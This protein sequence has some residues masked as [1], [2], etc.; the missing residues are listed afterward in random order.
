MIEQ[1]YM[2]EIER[3]ESIGLILH[4]SKIKRSMHEDIEQRKGSIII[5]IRISHIGM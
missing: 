5:V 3:I 1:N 2:I 4:F